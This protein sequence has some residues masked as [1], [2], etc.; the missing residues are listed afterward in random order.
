M[1][2]EEIGRVRRLHPYA[3]LWEPLEADASFVLRPMFGT[4]AAYLDGKL[5]LCFSAGEEPWRGVLVCTDHA[6]H[7]SLTADFPSL[8]PHPVLPKWL[9][10]AETSGDFERAAE[11]LVALA[12]R[13]DPRLGVVPKPRKRKRSPVA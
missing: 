13:R 5:V 11:R 7:A 2:S 3:W 1:H 12:K 8:S 4:R 10:L 6:H 9:Y